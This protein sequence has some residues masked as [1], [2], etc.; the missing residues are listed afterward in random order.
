M[1][2][3]VCTRL[4]I[5]FTSTATGCKSSA[6]KPAQETETGSRKLYQIH[7]L[8]AVNTW[9][10]AVI[11]RLEG[12]C[13]LHTHLNFKWH[14]RSFGGE[15]DMTFHRQHLQHS[16]TQTQNWGSTQ[17]PVYMLPEFEFFSLPVKH[18]KRCYLKE[19]GIKCWGFP[20]AGWCQ[21]VCANPKSLCVCVN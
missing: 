20:K 11:F 19:S 7:D 4:R 6:H 21:G 12:G 1:S 17:Y 14:K 16:L 13:C 8:F 10:L 3:W 2:I 18:T 9:C 5:N 15:I